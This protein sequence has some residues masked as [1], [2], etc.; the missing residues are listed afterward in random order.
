M[1]VAI[2]GLPKI[3]KI[4]GDKDLDIGNQSRFVLITKIVKIQHNVFFACLQLYQI[5]SS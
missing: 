5:Y 1:A 2:W 3:V 4:T